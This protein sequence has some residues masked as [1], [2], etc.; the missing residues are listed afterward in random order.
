[1]R[2]LVFPKASLVLLKQGKPPLLLN[3]GT[4]TA[5]DA[6]VFGQR[7]Q[8]EEGGLGVVAGPMGL[9][10]LHPEAAGNLGER[11]RLLGALDF[12]CPNE[13]IDPVDVAAESGRELGGAFVC[14]QTRELV[15]EECAVEGGVVGGRDARIERG[16]DLVRNGFEAR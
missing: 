13:R 4:I 9:L 12:T 11:F 1:M 8:N 10:Q 6:G 7:V 16:G 14:G 3:E 5:R 2:N 15:R